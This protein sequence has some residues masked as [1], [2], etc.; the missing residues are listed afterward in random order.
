LGL[1]EDSTTVALPKRTVE[2]LK[3]LMITPN[4]PYYHIIGRL[5]V[6]HKEKKRDEE[7][8]ELLK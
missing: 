1:K 8:K 4:E 3:V 2:E 6:E 7:T 5:I